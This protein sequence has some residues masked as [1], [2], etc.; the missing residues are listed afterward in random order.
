VGEVNLR[1]FISKYYKKLFGPPETNHFSM[2]EEINSDIPQ[3]SVDESNI[4]TAEFIE[5]E[6]KEAIMQME[7]N[8]APDLMDFMQNFIRSSGVLLKKV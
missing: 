4:L 5:E 8:K 3:V 7:H 2:M 1:L 6:V